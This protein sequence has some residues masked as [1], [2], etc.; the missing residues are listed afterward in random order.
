MAIIKTSNGEKVYSPDVDIDIF[1]EYFKQIS[2]N[3]ELL[4]PCVELNS[5]LNPTSSIIR[6]TTDKITGTISDVS[7]IGKSGL[8]SLNR[9]GGKNK[10]YKIIKVINKN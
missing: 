9:T 8:Q 6:S 5:T 4:N 3:D 2:D 7:E 1:N 10:K